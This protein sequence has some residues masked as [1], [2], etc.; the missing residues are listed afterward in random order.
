MSQIGLD[1]YHDYLAVSGAARE[2][3]DGWSY[4]G[5]T[6]GNNRKISKKKS[7]ESV[8]MFQYLGRTNQN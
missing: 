6:A 7:L 8:A 5:Q 4:G 3:Y 2:H 1:A